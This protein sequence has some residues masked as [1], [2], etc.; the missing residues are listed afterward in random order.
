METSEK[1]LAN[2]AQLRRI[3]DDP[4]RLVA[5]ASEKWSVP[6]DA[7]PSVFEWLAR[8]DTQTLLGA[9]AAT[10]QLSPQISAALAT[11]IRRSAPGIDLAMLRGRTENSKQRAIHL[12]TESA[13]SMLDR[14]QRQLERYRLQASLELSEM[15]GIASHGS[16]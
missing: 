1:E 5:L 12:L 11:S 13:T 9:I 4:Q 8:A 6:A 16:N 15:Q 10:Q 14:E 3:L 7:E 2:L